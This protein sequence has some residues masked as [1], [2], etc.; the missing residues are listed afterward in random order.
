M[1]GSKSSYSSAKSTYKEYQKESK[2]HEGNGMEILENPVINRADAM[3]IKKGTAVN[4]CDV[5]VSDYHPIKFLSDSSRSRTRTLL[6]VMLIHRELAHCAS[7]FVCR[8]LI[9]L[10]AH[11]S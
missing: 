11:C 6:Y 7:R 1:I 9:A 5:N 4:V 2:S 8:V 3:Y 10:A